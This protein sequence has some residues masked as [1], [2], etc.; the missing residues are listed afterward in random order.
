[1]VPTAQKSLLIQTKSRFL[2]NG[3]NGSK[4][5]SD[6]DKITVFTKWPQRLKNYEI[7]PEFNF[8]RLIIL[9]FLLIEILAIFKT[10]TL[11][12]ECH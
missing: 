8:W 12:V 4:I 5:S 1:M 10:S 7:E 6:S 11:L 9:K 2:Q 3:P